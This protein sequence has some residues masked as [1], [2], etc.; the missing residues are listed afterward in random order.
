MT[1]RHGHAARASRSPEYSAWANMI[2]RCKPGRLDADRYYLRGVTVCDRWNP[3]AGGSFDNFLADMGPRPGPKYSLDKDSIKPGNIVYCPEFCCWATPSEQ[4]TARRNTVWL[5]YQ[6]N[7]L[8]LQG[9]ANKLGIDRKVLARRLKLGWTVERVLSAPVDPTAGRKKP[10]RLIT[11]DGETRSLAD[12]ARHTGIRRH[13][14]S[15]R[16]RSGWSVAE[17]LGTPPMPSRHK[18]PSADTTRV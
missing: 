14:I 17:A 12:W 3:S 10:S 4:A 9:W 13:T 1:I 11:H 7:T 5:T 8:S 6:D 18:P 2:S 16:L 15:Y